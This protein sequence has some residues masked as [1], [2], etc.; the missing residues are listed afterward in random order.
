MPITVPGSPFAVNPT[1]GR[2]VQMGLHAA[3]E[4]R[5]TAANGIAQVQESFSKAE[6][7]FQDEFDRT[8]VMDLTNKLEQSRIDLRD[9]PETGYKS[10]LGDN[11]LTRPNGRSLQE[12]V[13]SNFR[14]SFD[15]IRKQAGNARQR[16]ALEDVYR[17]MSIQVDR[18]VATHVAHEFEVKRAAVEEETLRL[19]VL[20]ATSDDPETAMSG[21][22]AVRAQLAAL[23]KRAGVPVDKSKVLGGIHLGRVERMADAGDPETARAYLEKNQGEMTPSGLE[24]ARSIVRRADNAAA[25]ERDY[26]TILSEH[27]DDRRAAMAAARKAP[28]AYRKQLEADVRSYFVEKEAAEKREAAERE[29]AAMDYFYTYG[30]MPP[31]SLMEGVSKKT[32]YWLKTQVGKGSPSARAAQAAEEKRQELRKKSPVEAAQVEGAFGFTPINDWAQKGAFDQLAR[33]AA[34]APSMMA[35]W[36][37]PSAPLLSPDEVSGL[38]S[39]LDQSDPRTQERLLTGIAAAVEG[40]GVDLSDGWDPSAT[41]AD[42]LA[43]KY[44][45]AFLLASDN[46]ARAAGAVR[47]YLRGKVGIS[48]KRA[49]LTGL[50][51]SANGRG[52]FA[53]NLDGLYDDERTRS[54]V[55]DAVVGVAAGLALE[56]GASVWSGQDVDQAFRVVVG[57]IEDYNGRKVALR[58]VT[59]SDLAT[60]VRQLRATYS[61]EHLRDEICARLPNGQ[62]L[63]G[64]QVAAALPRAPLVPSRTGRDNCF[65]VMIGETLLLTDDGK[66][67]E[68]EVYR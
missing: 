28:A 19:S 24:R 1:G 3:P 11:A 60:R 17:R 15:E 8:R 46:E 26:N 59:M 40:A 39:M 58:G 54:A 66:P 67:F 57:D 53:A 16:A 62:T 65:Q 56:R 30:T 36:D 42:Q 20:E 50:D 68:V 25:L 14:A 61:D 34:Q 64:A 10:L 55:L 2:T 63:T 44:G 32:E 45:T 51:S 6:Q 41:M 47:L 27:P 7:V 52:T 29:Q 49:E 35:A 31:P 23:E 43:G 48:E 9:N 33:R 38:T 4:V 21:E 37:I 12:E 5:N 13:Q 22:A 18:D